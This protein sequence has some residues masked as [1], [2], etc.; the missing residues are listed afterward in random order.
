MFYDHHSAHSLNWLNG[1]DEDDL[2]PE[3]EDS[4]YLKRL[5][6][7]ETRST[8]SVGK[9]TIMDLISNF[10]PTLGTADSGI[11]RYITP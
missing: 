2:K 5:H 6:Q 7:N 9:L 3:P 1:V 10:M 8:G 4:R 11:V